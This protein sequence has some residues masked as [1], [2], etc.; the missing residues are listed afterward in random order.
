M[1]IVVLLATWQALPTFGIVDAFLLPP[2]TTVLR[3]LV[4]LAGPDANPSFALWLHIFWSVFRLAAGVAIGCVIG[5]P[6]GLAMG[7]SKLVSLSFRPLLTVILAIP[8]LALA[9]I[10]ILFLG[11]NNKVAIAVIAIEATVLMAYNAELG[12]RA[13]PVQMRWA[14]AS[15]GAGRFTV[16]RR[17]VLPAS[18]PPLVTAMKLSVGYGWRALIAVESIAATAYGLGYMIFE[19][20]SFMDTHTIFAGILSIAIVGFTLERLVFGRLEQRING[21]YAISPK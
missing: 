6:L 1:A 15:M 13:V 20:Q 18:L 4:T 14:L 10:L 2:P 21:W 16:F 9:P 3:Q 17:V 8:S 7:S 11:L 5:V 19:A 12:A